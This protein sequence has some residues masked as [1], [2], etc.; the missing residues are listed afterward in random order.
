MINFSLPIPQ[1]ELMNMDVA[2][3]VEYSVDN[4]DY[5]NPV[6]F[7][8]NNTLRD[9]LIRMGIEISGKEIPEHAFVEIEPHKGQ[10][11]LNFTWVEIDYFTKESDE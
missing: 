1:F 3:S 7:E 6:E 2:K 10:Y 5:N 4:K 8:G 9:I 11:R